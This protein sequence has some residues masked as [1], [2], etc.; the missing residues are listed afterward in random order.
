MRTKIIDGKTI[1]EKIKDQI[2]KEVLEFNRHKVQNV[3]I[4]PNLAVILVGVNKESEIY[5]N[6]KIEEAKKVGIDT[7]LYRFCEE[8]S[9]EDIIETIQILNQDQEIDAI[10]VQLPLLNKFD[11]NKVIEAI[12]PKK[13]VDCFHPVNQK[14]KVDKIIAPVHGAVLEILKEAKYN[15]KGKNVLVISNSE[16]FSQNLKTILERQKASVEGILFKDVS[17]EEK[18]SKAD[19]LIS[20]VGKPHFIEE[21]M[22]KNKA[23]IIDV[24]FFR[25]GKRIKGD[26]DPKNLQDKVSFYTP[27]PGGVGPITVAILLRNTLE[28]FKI[29]KK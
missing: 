20:A 27:V 12:D 4:R 17:L 8:D 23:G 7:H 29:R 9:Q 13:D 25:E 14:R 24:G 1:A 3:E 22:L 19:L 28:L 26:L 16:V 21:S 5:V 2:V 15:V 10:L 18:I 11:V 6:K